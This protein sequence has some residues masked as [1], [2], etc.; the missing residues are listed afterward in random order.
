MNTGSLQSFLLAIL[1]GIA[2]AA[3]AV[4]NLNMVI[5]LGI[6][7]AVLFIRHL[8]DW[9]VYVLGAIVGILLAVLLG[10]S[11]PEQALLIV[12]LGSVMF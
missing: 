9:I 2:I 11:L 7:V 4:L 3:V 5:V 1:W 12:V 8:G 10:V 6:A